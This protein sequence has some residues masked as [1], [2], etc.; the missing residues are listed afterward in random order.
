MRVCTVHVFSVRTV[1][2]YLHIPITVGAEHHT[3]LAAAAA[4]TPRG[5]SEWE[6]DPIATY[7]GGYGAA[8]VMVQAT[9]EAEAICQK[10]GLSAVDVLRPFGRVTQAMTVTTVGEPYRLRS[11]GMRFV[12][13]NEFQ[14]VDPANADAHLTKLLESHDCTAEI[15][16]AEK[17][18]IANPDGTTRPL[19][20]LMSVSTPWLTAFRAQ[21]AASLRHADGASLDHPVGCVLLASASEPKLANVFNALAS[22]A[23]LAPVI[24]D[25][26]ADPNLPR[27]YILLHDV[28]GSAVDAAGAQKALAEVSRVLGASACHLLP[29]NSRPADAPL[30]EDVWSAAR[31][32]LH[33][34]PSPVLPALP[35]DSPISEEDVR[36]LQ[37]IV[38]SG[39]AKQVRAA[40][41]TPQACSHACALYTPRPAHLMVK[42]HA[43]YTRRLFH[44]T[45]PFTH[46]PAPRTVGWSAHCTHCA[47]H[48]LRPALGR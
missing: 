41:F 42:G 31:P 12:H 28:S 35:S 26:S 13:T 16:D 47:L 5:M 8:V 11:F 30:P 29:F 45:P 44:P 2:I 33:A 38:V 7:L 40:L 24:A 9:K 4:P 23:S 10:S 15:T 14:E 19:P 43:L 25:G 17:A 27:T 46:R 21:L 6:G 34:S 48:P 36:R 20:P 3:A 32:R 39:V 18:D 37:E 1:C 22:S